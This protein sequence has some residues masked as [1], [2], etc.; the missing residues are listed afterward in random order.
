M[1]LA[2]RLTFILPV[3]AVVGLVLTAAVL[4]A[5][6]RRE[7][8]ATQERV[9]EVTGTT[10]VIAEFG[11]NADA[12]YLA[13]AADPSLRTLVASIAHAPEWGINPAAHASGTRTTYTVLPPAARP[14]RETPAEL[15]LF[16]VTSGAET[17]LASD[18]DLLTAPV[19]DRAG[20]HIVY[21]ANGESDRQSLVSVEVA[22]GQRKVL[23]TV[24][25]LF[26][27][28]PVGFA[29]DGALLYANL[30]QSGTDLFRL[31]PTGGE[32]ALLLHASDQV[33]RDWDISPDGTTISFVA[34]ETHDERIVNRLQVVR[35][36]STKR[37]AV[38]AA[39]TP[40]STDQFSP[41]WTPDGSGITV[42]REAYPLQTAP[43][44]TYHLNGGAPIALA[45]PREGYDVPLS[46]SEDGQYL[47]ALSFDGNSASNPGDESLVMIAQDGQR[48]T[49]VS[50]TQV[51]FLGWLAARG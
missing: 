19:F 26:G 36:D 45:T 38:P 6:S 11:L 24:E 40:A 37:V 51:L 29:A 48:R 8:P 49:V 41:V 18:A 30:S 23:Y 47:A 16:D 32:P 35:L 22:T 10:A 25:T 33:A 14:A 4:L 50:A 3:A 9:I 7:H 13:S 12:I 28:Y 39:E 1:P 34:P 17:L 2:R 27:I 21:R 15:R 42:G 31:A 46:W 44:V 43:A 20:A 5:V